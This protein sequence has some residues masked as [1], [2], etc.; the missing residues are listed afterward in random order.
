MVTVMGI[1]AKGKSIDLSG[2]K[3]SVEKEMSSDLP[4]RIA[5]LGIVLEMPLPSGHPEGT[6]LVEVAMTC[7][8]HESIHPEI[9]VDLTWIWQ[10]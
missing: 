2:L 3:A 9:E 10:D 5:R 1:Y 7:P 4:R 6:K 8:V